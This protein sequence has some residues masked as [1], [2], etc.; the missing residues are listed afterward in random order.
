[1]SASPLDWPHHSLYGLT[2]ASDFPFANRFVAGTGPSDLTFTRSFEAPERIGLEGATPLYGKAP[3]SRGGGSVITIYSLPDGEAGR[4]RLVVRF[5]GSA[6]YYLY[7]DRIVA[8]LLNPAYD[9]LVEIQFLGHVLSLWMESKGIAMLHASAVVINERAHVFLASNKGGKSSLAASLMQGGHPMLTDDI[10]PVEVGSDGEVIGQPGYPQMR[11]WPDQATHFLGGYEDLEIV[12]PGFDKRRVPVGSGGVGRFHRRPVP[13]GCLW[14]PE[15][16]EDRTELAIERLA[17]RELWMRLLAE[18]FVAPM[19]EALGWQPRRME[20]LARM[21]RTV[22]AYRVRYPRSMER[23]A[24]VGEEI[25]AVSAELE[26]EDSASLTRSA[27][28]GSS[29]AAAAKVNEEGTL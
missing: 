29:A 16:Q 12:H 21:A 17:P 8:H 22:P 10:L 25:L 11:L 1:M 4:D 2:M 28:K 7:P 27:I 3:G 6:D 19:V 20:T 26:R 24:A 5:R 14:L 23:L 18:G 9:Y 15:L 13:L